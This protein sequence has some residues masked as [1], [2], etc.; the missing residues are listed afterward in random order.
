MNRIDSADSH[1]LKCAKKG[2]GSE[3]KDGGAMPLRGRRRR[4]KRISL[5]KGALIYTCGKAK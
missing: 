5:R 1:S 2:K 4:R 3:L